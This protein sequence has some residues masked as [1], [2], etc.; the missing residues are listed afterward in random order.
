MKDT[1]HGAV[2]SLKS[3]GKRRRSA[4]E[5]EEE[6]KEKPIDV[7]AETNGRQENGNGRAEEEKKTQETTVTEA[8]DDDD[9]SDGEEAL[10]VLE[11]CDFKNHPLFDD[12]STATLEGIDTATPMLRIGEYALHGQLEETVGTSYFYDTDTT[13]VPDKTYQFAGQT[14]K[15]IKFTIAPPEDP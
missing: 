9:G 13:R 3:T 15:K 2:T 1:G 11:L 5:E 10:V 7:D 12:Y 8:A 4:P 14:I 6:M